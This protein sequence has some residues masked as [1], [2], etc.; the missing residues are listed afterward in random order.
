MLVSES[1]IRK[2]IKDAIIKEIGFKKR[3]KLGLSGGSA[4]VSSVVSSEEDAFVNV[5]DGDFIHPVLKNLDGATPGL[6]SPPQANRTV[7][8]PDGSSKTGDHKGYDVPMPIGYP[9]VRVAAGTVTQVVQNHRVAGNYIAVKHDSN[10]V[11]DNNTTLY[12]HLSKT[13]VNKGDKVTPG[14]LIGKSGN[15]GASTGPHL[16]FT[17]AS[18]GRLSDYSF[19]KAEY[20]GFFAKCKQGT[21][22]KS[23]QNAVADSSPE[24]SSEEESSEA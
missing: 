20:E 17:I 1:L 12:M 13:L 19:N 24:E 10:I 5:P 16:H 4:S 23:Q 3:L 21:Y 18:S 15:T 2:I 7:N 11:N 8:F 6:G 9:I 22:S 14:Q